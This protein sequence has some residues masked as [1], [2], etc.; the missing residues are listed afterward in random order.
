MSEQDTQEFLGKCNILGEL[1]LS[2]RDDEQFIDFVE[3]N[4]LGL[5]LAYAFANDIAKETELAE[6]YINESYDLLTQALGVS[7]TEP[8]DSLEAMLEQS[9]NR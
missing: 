6:R 5:P 9:T 3:Y 7:D 8:F 1:W 2:Y 4:D